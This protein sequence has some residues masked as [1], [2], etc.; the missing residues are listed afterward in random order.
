MPM[1]ICNSLCRILFNILKFD[2]RKVILVAV[3]ASICGS[4]LIADWQA[5]EY[6]SCRQYSVT[7]KDLIQENTTDSKE[8]SHGAG[9]DQ[10]HSSFVLPCTHLEMTREGLSFESR[11]KLQW[12]GNTTD[13]KND[14]YPR[15]VCTHT[16]NLY[17]QCACSKYND[18][19]CIGFKITSAGSCFEFS[20]ANSV[21]MENI[22]YSAMHCD[23]SG[24]SISLNINVINANTFTELEV[25]SFK[26]SVLFVTKF[27]MSL[28]SFENITSDAHIQGDTSI[29]LNDYSE[30]YDYGSTA[31][32]F[33]LTRSEI[34]MNHSGCHWNQFS[35]IT[36]TDCFSCP[37]ICHSV[38]QSLNFVQFSLGVTIFV[39]AIP[40]SRVAL[41]VLISNNLNKNEQVSFVPTYYWNNILEG[42]G[43]G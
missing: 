38:K 1:V 37:P 30:D 24:S 15:I 16:K 4:T 13:L 31:V 25:D 19:S 27:M 20:M 8:I 11:R 5:I 22:S 6:D 39:L 41:M 36:K 26:E 18:S 2:T 42:G 3:V 17:P 33:L 35:S 10:M 9:I 29:I 28:S 40:I 21:S 14:D 32:Q 43:G 12:E 23:I 34:C 7:H